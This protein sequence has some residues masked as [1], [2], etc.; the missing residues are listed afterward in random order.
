[1]VG[2][3]W[4][5]TVDFVKMVQRSEAT[6]KERP[7]RLRTPQR[8][9]QS[10]EHS[11]SQSADETPWSLFVDKQRHG[12]KSLIVGGPI[13][14][15]ETGEELHVKP[16]FSYVTRSGIDAFL[17]RCAAKGRP[18]G[19]DVEEEND[20]DQDEEEEAD[21]EVEEEARDVEAEE[22]TGGLASFDD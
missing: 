7:L 21:E 4:R 1:M 12:G 15:P 16:Q 9:A 10:A 3:K 14:D 22:D 18:A 17:A 6:G 2:G 19:C 8:K 5:Y 20:R 11:T 13:K